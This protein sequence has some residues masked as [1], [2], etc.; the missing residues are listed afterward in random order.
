MFHSGISNGSP[1]YLHKTK[2]YLHIREYNY[3]QI[4]GL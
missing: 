3:V 4:G 1:K 2:N